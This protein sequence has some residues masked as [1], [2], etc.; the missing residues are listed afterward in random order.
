MTIDGTSAP[1]F[2]GSP[3]VTI[4][5]QGSKGL[6]F[7]KGAVG[8]TLSAL[9]LIRAGNAGVTLSASN[10]TLER[11]DIGL[12]SNGTTV[13]GNRG[14]GVRINASSH[15]DLI[16]RIDPV[17]SVDYYPT[18]Y[19]YT[20]NGTSMPVSGWQGIRASGTSG[21]YLIT[22]T[23]DSNGLLYDGP[24][25]GVGGTAYAVD[26]SGAATTSVYGPDL[27]SNGQLRLVGSYTTGNGQTQ[28]FLFQGTLAD[29]SNSSDY[30]TIDDPN[31]TYTYIHSTMGDLAVGNGGD[32]R[33][34]T[35]NAFI[36]SVSQA[37]IVTGILYPGS[38]GTSAY[39]IWYNGGTSYT[40]CGGYTALLQ[41]GEA[42]FGGYLVDYDSSTGLFTHW[43]SFSDPNGQIGQS[44]ATHFQ[45]ISSTEAGVYTL[46]A[47]ST[48]PGSDT[49]LA[50]SIA[51]VRRNPDGTFGPAV[52][53]DLSDPNL[54]A[55]LT[56]DAVEGNQVV[57]IGF[58]NSGVVSYQAT[59]NT[60]FQLSNVISGNRGNGIGIYG[61]SGDTI[62]MN[63]IGTDSSGTLRR[64]NAKNG[65]LVS[66]G[67]RANLIGGQATGGNDPTADEIV[68]P[69]QGNLISGNRGNG[70]LITGR[71]TQNMLSGNFVGTTATGDTA[72]G[73]RRDGSGDR[74]GQWQSIDR[75][76][77][78]AESVCLLQR[79]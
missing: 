42:P 64:G 20:S 66:N 36:Y 16:G 71:A 15:G 67:A 27:L 41:P 5:F 30:R 74:E 76:H 25:S 58:T 32:V 3:V 45:G 1:G 60:G 48:Q 73:N 29:L 8:S 39:G 72:L 10:V 55:P 23:S 17:S 63:N 31:D 51:S 19:V 78:P 44:L 35:D 53:T 38:T 33:G 52:W 49:V 43:T 4:H 61:A 22:G 46:A 21:Q 75:L 11:N 69:P 54:Q 14:D 28:G 62:A 12:L 77:V 47:N 34:E 2:N 79:A 9:S 13:A 68:R 59:I 50:A 37:K 24:I 18:Q 56:A 57:G 40:I 26:Y 70:V 6:N 7:A 65:I